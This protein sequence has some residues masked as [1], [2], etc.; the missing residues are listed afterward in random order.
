M[1]ISEQYSR[2]SRGS[3]SLVAQEVVMRDES[4][5]PCER[6]MRAT[7]FGQYIA[8]GPPTSLSG[9]G[10]DKLYMLRA[11]I[12]DTTYNVNGQQVGSR[13][14]YSVSFYMKGFY[15]FF[16]GKGRLFLHFIKGVLRLRIILFLNLP[17]SLWPLRTLFQ[18]PKNFA[19]AHG[20]ALNTSY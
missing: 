8:D 12:R 17:R 7:P 10:K 19:D 2:A 3:L 4:G 18:V 9:S 1:S 5:A 15:Y 11:S 16:D 20:P 13:D 6:G 14:V